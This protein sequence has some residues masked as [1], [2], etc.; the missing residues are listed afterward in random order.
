MA[1]PFKNLKQKISQEA[2]ARAEK[3]AQQMLA[4][5]PLNELRA[6]RL[7]TQESIAKS[8]GIN[9]AAVSK[10]ERRADMYVSTLR[11][12]IAAMGGELEIT[13]RFPDGAVKIQQ[14]EDAESDEP[15]G[16]RS[17]A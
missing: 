10:M 9:Q 3:R 13:A 8:L 5:M 12:F 4:E 7:R 6:A 16:V 15:A 11:D 1:K 14:F 2:Q 17:A